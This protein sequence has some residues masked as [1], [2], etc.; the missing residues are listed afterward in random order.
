MPIAY[1]VG[2]SE[3]EV[4]TELQSSEYF[5]AN[6]GE[7][8]NIEEIFERRRPDGKPTRINAR[9][10]FSDLETAKSWL[11]TKP[12]HH[13]CEIL[14][15]EADIL[16]VGDWKWLQQ[17]LEKGDIENCA[18]KYWQGSNTDKPVVE[19][20]IKRGVIKSEIKVEARERHNLF[21]K[22]YGMPSPEDI[23]KS[24]YHKP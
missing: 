2:F 23:A 18:D 11:S 22:R 14:V 16:H 19:W 15:E 1:R 5:Y 12:K 4:N 21:A 20:I 8:A 3:S 24:Y 9:F 17:A 6:L 7:R 10:V 13:L